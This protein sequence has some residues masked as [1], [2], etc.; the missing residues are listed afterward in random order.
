[1]PICTMQLSF[2]PA[3]RKILGKPAKIASRSVNR[4]L[5]LVPTPL[6]FVIY[7]KIHNHCIIKCVVCTGLFL[8]G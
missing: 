6:D 5:F 1:M 2:P 7:I 4:Q 8:G 3:I